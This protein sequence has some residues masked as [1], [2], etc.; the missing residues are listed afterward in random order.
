MAETAKTNSITVVN[1][2][3]S[4]SV[5]F[6]GEIDTGRTLVS[7]LV[8]EAVHSLGLPHNVPYSAIDAQDQKINGT[9]TLDEAG[10]SEET[11]ISLAPEA[12]AGGGEGARGSS[13]PPP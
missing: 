2:N 9:D 10:L 1:P 4:K 11:T 7:E 3:R 5:T 6:E 12:V 13:C 8:K